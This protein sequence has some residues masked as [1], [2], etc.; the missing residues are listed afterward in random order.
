MLVNEIFRSISGE[1]STSGLPTIFL[2]L[3]GCNLAKYGGCS[4]C[5]TRYAFSEGEEMD[6]DE[7]INEIEYLFEEGDNLLI[8]GGEPLIQVD[9]INKLT[10][11][12]RHFGNL[13]LKD[14]SIETNGSIDIRKVKRRLFSGLRIIMDWKCPSSNMNK[15]MLKLNL[16]Y[17]RKKDELK[18]VIGTLDDYREM[19]NVIFQN[20]IKC[21]IIVSTVWDKISRQEVVEMMLK[22]GVKARFQVQLH[23]IIWD[24]DKRGV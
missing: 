18:F 13:N 6:V 20:K 5:D 8:T 2:R 24:K 23:K 16:K 14:I 10:W 17:L 15:H 12:I 22:D 21:Q 19:L 1:S 11:K 9:E 3:T 7:V 4:F